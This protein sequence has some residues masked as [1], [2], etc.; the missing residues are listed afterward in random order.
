MKALTIIDRLIESEPPIFHRNQLQSRQIFHTW[1]P[2][3]AGLT[4]ELEVIPHRYWEEH[5][6]TQHMPLTLYGAYKISDFISQQALHRLEGI[7]Q[8]FF[9]VMGLEDVMCIFLPPTSPENWNELVEKDVVIGSMT[10]T[11]SQRNFTERDRLILNLFRPHL[12]QAYENAR[13]FG[14]VEQNLTQLHQ[15]LDRLGLIILNISGQIELITS[16][17]IQYLQTYFPDSA[18][19]RYLPDYLSAWVKHQISVE[20]PTRLPLRIEQD[21]KQLVISLTLEPNK[22][23]FAMAR[24]H[25]KSIFGKLGLQSSTAAIADRAI[26]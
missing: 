13:R 10:L 26:V 4:P 11:R 9:Q 21:G 7:Y 12:F 15:D 6:I 17:A 24:K 20:T 2:G 3:R 25:L 18:N 8:Q 16:V 14:R 22:N 5:P 1:L 19:L 23:R